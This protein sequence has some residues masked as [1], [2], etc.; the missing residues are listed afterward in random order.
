MEREEG[1]GKRVQIAKA[2]QPC[3]VLLCSVPAVMLCA[4][5]SVTGLQQAGE[6]ISRY[7]LDV[8]GLYKRAERGHVC[9][10]ECF[11]PDGRDQR[12]GGIE[13]RLGV[14]HL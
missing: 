1:D 4:V 5:L 7:Q 6:T 12:T 9:I 8:N 10:C 11:G 2:D 14:L 13:E 3:S